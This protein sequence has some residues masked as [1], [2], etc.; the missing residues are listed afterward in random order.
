[1]FLE[2]NTTI[3]CSSCRFLEINP[4]LFPLLTG[5]G[6]NKMI[7]RFFDSSINRFGQVAARGGYTTGYAAR[8]CAATGSDAG[9]YA[10]SPHYGGYYTKI[11]D[12]SLNGDSAPQPAGPGC[13]RQPD[14]GVDGS[15]TRV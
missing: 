15:R 6:G 11:F 4:L 2:L 13:R 10:C 12:G 14:P 1:M 9:T 7:Y 3:P 8:R 5:G